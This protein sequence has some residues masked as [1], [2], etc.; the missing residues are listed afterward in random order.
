[1]AR[2]LLDRPHTENTPPSAN[3][4]ALINYV[5]DELIGHDDEVGQEELGYQHMETL[6]A[7][8]ICTRD[9]ISGIFP[10]TTAPVSGVEN[11]SHVIVT[12]IILE[13][14]NAV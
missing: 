7:S 10:T 13:K 9:V 6:C 8:V 2:Y 4:A 12:A 14:F 3:F 5:L 1:M 11:F